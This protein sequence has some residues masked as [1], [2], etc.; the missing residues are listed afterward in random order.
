M[1]HLSGEPSPG[2]LGL[3][4]QL[5]A[6]RAVPSELLRASLHISETISMAS[7]AIAMPGSSKRNPG[8]LGS[9]VQLA[10]VQTQSEELG[11]LR[12]SNRLTSPILDVQRLPCCNS[13][14]LMF[15]NLVIL[16]LLLGHDFQTYTVEDVRMI[17]DGRFSGRPSCAL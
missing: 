2:P 4:L 10:C 5:L 13:D 14:V 6:I 7:N 9:T 17:E 15:L 1:L 11:V 16:V 8:L 3:F 12:L